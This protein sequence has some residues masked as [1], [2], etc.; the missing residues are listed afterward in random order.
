M[1]CLIGNGSQ[2]IKHIS[3]CNVQLM[4]I[5]PNAST[6]LGIDEKVLGITLTIMSYHCCM[7]HYGLEQ[8]A[9]TVLGAGRY[10]GKGNMM[11]DPCH[12]QV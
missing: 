5:S 3:V 1:C 10:L 2:R 6:F 11:V 8:E 9:L 7:I 12:K 4:N